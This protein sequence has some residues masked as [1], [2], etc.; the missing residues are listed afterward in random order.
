MKSNALIPL[1]P[2]AVLIRAFMVM[3]RARML[4]EKSMI[5]LKQG[6]IHFHI[7]GP[8]HEAIQIA[9]AMAMRPGHDWA[10]PYY[11]DLAFALQLGVTPYE[12]RRISDTRLCEFL[13]NRVRQGPNFCRRWVQRLER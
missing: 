10:Y 6:K 5:M 13:P 3:Q 12:G 11:R 4:D 9:A 2:D 7:S 8:G 1:P